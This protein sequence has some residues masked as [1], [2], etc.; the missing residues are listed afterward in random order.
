VPSAETRIR[1]PNAADYLARLCGHLSKLA[2][3]DRP[4]GHGPLPHAR[5]RRPPGVLNAEHTQDAGTVTLSWGR[6]T[7]HAAAGELTVRAHADSQEDLRRIQ[8]MTAGR[9]ATFGRHEHLDIQWTP[10]ADAADEPC[11]PG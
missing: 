6:L 1:T 8:D 7:L 3:A 9:L 10:V 4:P 2:A 5:G 11:Q